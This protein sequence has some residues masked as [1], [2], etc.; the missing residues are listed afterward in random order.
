[1]T[2]EGTWKRYYRISIEEN[3]DDASPEAKGEWN[4][5][6]NL[7]GAYGW[8]DYPVSKDTDG[9]QFK[10]PP[11]YPTPMAGNPAMN[12]ADPIAGAY[13]AE[14]GSLPSAVWPE[15]IDRPLYVAMGGQAKVETAGS[16]AL[17]AT[18]FATLVS[19]A[20]ALDTQSNG[21]EM[22]KFTVAGADD[23]TAAVLQIKR[24]TTVLETIT[25]G[26]KA[27]SPNGVYYSKGAYNGT[28]S[29]NALSILATGAMG[30][31]PTVAVAGVDY[32]TTTFS[33][34]SSRK[35]LAI[36]QGGRQEAGSGNSEYFTGCILPTLAFNYDRAA[37]DGLLLADAT[38]Q[39]MNRTAATAKTYQNDTAAYYRP[40]AAW[41]GAASI[42]G[43]ASTEIVA[44]SF[45]LQNNDSLY[46]VSS[47][48]QKSSGKIPGEYEVFGEL[49]VLPA[50]ET[51]WNDYINS[52][53]RILVLDF[54][55]PFYVVDTTPYQLQFTFSRVFLGD[56]NRN[57]QNMAQGAGLPFRAV[58]NATDV[59][60]CKVVKV[61]RMPY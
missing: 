34:A 41:A 32:V 52:V 48:L 38:L 40:F 16:A 35:T 30:G 17:A 45:T 43:A 26:T 23:A 29:G 47:G 2:V 60:A 15:F 10:I 39:G 55:T 46:A 14:L 18:A 37:A 25:I 58:Y 20:V 13:S 3:P 50:D 5:G 49:T 61:D 28:G 21:T 22:L 33:W 36:E 6:G 19:G 53:N 11:I 57:R 54:K 7:G 1:M 51:R 31:T 24:G 59:G 56:Y 8:M 4:I 12:T 27:T 9:L 44:A 42:D